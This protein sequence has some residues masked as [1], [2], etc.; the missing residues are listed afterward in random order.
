MKFVQRYWGLI[1]LALLL[2]M[3]WTWQ[4]GPPVLYALSGLVIFWSLFTAPAWCGAENSKNSKERYCRNNS[5]GLMFGCHLRKHRW[6]K[7]KLLFYNRRWADFSRGLWAS[8]PARLATVSGVIGTVSAVATGVR[9][10][11]PMV[12]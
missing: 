5:Y 10:F 4:V 7:F 2:T 9:D 6:Q 3:W 11:G 8:T 12:L 1:L